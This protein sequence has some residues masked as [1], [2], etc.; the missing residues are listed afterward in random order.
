M[1][2]GL[3]NLFLILQD[4]HLP[5]VGVFNDCVEKLAAMRNYD[6]IV[7]LVKMIGATG[8]MTDKTRDD[9]LLQVVRKIN[10]TEGQVL[11]S[12]V[13]LILVWVPFYHSLLFKYTVHVFSL[14]VLTV[15]FDEGYRPETSVIF[16]L[17]GTGFVLVLF[18]EMLQ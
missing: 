7:D 8:M 4:Y 10:Q 9:L 3:S 6:L 14:F 11:N 13:L 12:L 5:A 2:V 18:K 1:L 17:L 16:L 15:T